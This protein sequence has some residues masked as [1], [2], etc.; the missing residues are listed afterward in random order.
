[1]WSDGKASI[2]SIPDSSNRFLSLRSLLA[3]GTFEET[4]DHELYRCLEK[5]LE[6]HKI[7][8]GV[9]APKAVLEFYLS[10]FRTLKKR[11]ESGDL[12]QGDRDEQG[13]GVKPVRRQPDMWELSWRWDEAQMRIYHMETPEKPHWV[14]AVKAHEK[15]IAS[16]DSVIISRLQDVMMD[17]GTSRFQAESRHM[18][19]HADKY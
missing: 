16:N 17:E 3:D 4:V 9:A 14:L 11:A 19:G 15:D 12:V 8:H 7:A 1:M 6:D 2:C 18:W 5:V 10:T 13:Q